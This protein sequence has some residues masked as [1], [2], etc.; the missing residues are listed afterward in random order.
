MNEACSRPPRMRLSSTY[1]LCSASIS[2]LIGINVIVGFSC[3]IYSTKYYIDFDNYSLTLGLNSFKLGLCSSIKGFLR[4]EN[5]IRRFF[6]SLYLSICALT[7]IIGFKSC[8]GSSFFPS[9]V[10]IGLSCVRTFER[11]R[12]GEKSTI[13]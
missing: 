3:Y 12:T 1:C 13:D 5:V 7:R 6:S 8:L 4:L 2:I 10:K 9:L 11:L